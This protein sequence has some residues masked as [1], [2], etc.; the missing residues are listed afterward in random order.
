M[1]TDK[2]KEIEAAMRTLLDRTIRPSGHHIPEHT[3]RVAEATK[4]ILR[5][6]QIVSSC[7]QAA[8]REYEFTHRHRYPIMVDDSVIRR[9]RRN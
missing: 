2:H 8:R 7:L 4:I 5:C 1:G 3:P 6:R 9:D